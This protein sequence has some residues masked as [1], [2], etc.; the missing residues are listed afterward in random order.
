MTE[1]EDRYTRA[2]FAMRQREAAANRKQLR[3]GI[4]ITLVVSFL[5]WAPIIWW[6]LS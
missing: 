4:L 3:L 1:S 6:L 5:F 2:L